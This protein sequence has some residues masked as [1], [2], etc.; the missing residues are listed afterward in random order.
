MAGL[1]IQAWMLG[2]G[3]RQLSNPG[4]NPPVPDREQLGGHKL[5]LVVGEVDKLQLALVGEGVVR[6][7]DQLVVAEVQLEQAGETL[8]GG[9]ADLP[10][11]VV[12]DVEVG[13]TAG[14][15]QTPRLQLTDP[16]LRKIQSLQGRE[17]LQQQLA[18]LCDSQDMDNRSD[19]E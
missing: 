14:P 16:V 5:D 11:A 19:E 8:E 3:T 2:R 15:L 10:Q 12:G 1:A 9:G 18:D 13:E 6:Q 4:L 17:R 7:G